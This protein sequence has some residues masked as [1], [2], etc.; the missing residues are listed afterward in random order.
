MDKRR[1]QI[2]CL[3][4][5]NYYDNRNEYHLADQILT[6]LEPR[7]SE[8]DLAEICAKC[9]KDR[10]PKMSEEEIEKIVKVTLPFG[11]EWAKDVAHALAGK[12]DEPKSEKCEGWNGL[13][14][15]D[16]D[17]NWHCIHGRGAKQPL[18]EKEPRKPF[19]QCEHWKGR[20]MIESTIDD[21]SGCSKDTCEKYIPEKEPR[22]ECAGHCEI[23]LDDCVKPSEC[24]WFVKNS[25]KE[26]QIKETPKRIERLPK[27][28]YLNI[29]TEEYKFV[30]F[31]KEDAVKIIDKIDEVIQDRN[32]RVGNGE[33][34]CK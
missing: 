3:I 5:N 25:G 33:G 1:E 12:I 21:Y 19:P 17:S 22:K 24:K 16:N 9:H 32:D 6:A 14:C 13:I 8:E 2:A 34:K 15:D 28:K 27:L 7:M 29:E 26:N 4:R 18:P 10:E 30:A 23:D 11:K 31:T 20:C